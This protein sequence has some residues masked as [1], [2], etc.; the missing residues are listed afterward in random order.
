MAAQHRPIPKNAE[1]L[2]DGCHEETLQKLELLEKI[3]ADFRYEG[4][5][6]RGKNLKGALALLDYFNCRLMDHFKMEDKILF[7]FLIVHLPK[8][9]SVIG[10]LRSE[11]QDFRNCLRNFSK[12]LKNISREKT[13]NHQIREIEKLNEHG[14]YLIYLLR[15]HFQVESECLYQAIDRDLHLEERKELIKRCLS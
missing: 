4:K 2:F 13:G 11:H 12:S 3:L 6:S 5:T 7:P 1:A 10:L 14:T 15:N 9:E 8:L